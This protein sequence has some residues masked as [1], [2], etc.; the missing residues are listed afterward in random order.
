MAATMRLMVVILAVGMS[1]YPHQGYA[2]DVEPNAEHAKSYATAKTPTPGIKQ[3]DAGPTRQDSER[4]QADPKN[5]RRELLDR[6]VDPITLFTGL[7]VVVGLAQWR[8]LRRQVDRMTDQLAVATTAANATKDSVIAMEASTAVANQALAHSRETAAAQL[9][10]V[11][12]QN[13]LSRATAQ[14]EL[15]AYVFAPGAQLWNVKP[16]VPTPGASERE[17]VDVAKFAKAGPMAIVKIENFG[18]TPAYSFSAEIWM[19]L[20]DPRAPDLPKKPADP[21]EGFGK[22][23]R[24]A[25]MPPGSHIFQTVVMG[26]PLTDEERSS[27]Q[28]GTA[29]FYVYGEI[30]YRDIFNIVVISGFSFVHTAAQY[31]THGVVIDDSGS[32]NF[33]NRGQFQQVMNTPWPA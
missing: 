14:R 13:D 15:C 21:T 11:R 10:E 31:G 19:R 8:A 18:R 4:Q 20:A 24:R 22:P 28:N 12:R 27:I 9:A 7:L 29:A 6:L 25:I 23:F 26:T 2:E 1:T 16:G 3:N 32:G 17:K 5:W 30:R 33:E